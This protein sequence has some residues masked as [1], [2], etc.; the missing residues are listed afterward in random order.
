MCIN[1][2]KGKAGG[3]TWEKRRD[4]LDIVD[5]VPESFKGFILGAEL[6]GLD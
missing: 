6:D 3:D 1:A 2:M 4:F 5:E